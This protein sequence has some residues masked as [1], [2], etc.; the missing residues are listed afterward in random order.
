MSMMHSSPVPDQPYFAGLDA[1]S[2]QVV[3]AVVDRQGALVHEASVRTAEP[4]RLAEALAPYHTP[5]H[6]L[7]VVVETCPFWPWLY[8]LLVPRGITFHLA[9]AQELEAIAAAPRKSDQRDARLLARMLAAGLIPEAYAKPPA[10][11]ER[12]CLVR[13]RAALVRHRTM[14]ANRIHGQLHAAGLLL[15]R[16]CLLRRAARAWLRDTAGPV[17]RP[18]QRRLVQSHWQLVRRLTRMIHQL[19]RVIAAAAAAEPAAVLLAT[20]PGIGAYRG[21]LL[22]TELLPM[23]RYASE[24]KFVG[25]AGLAPI[26]R[27]SA[28]T[29][30]H[31]PLPNA[32]N[33]WVRGALISSVP[34]HLRWAPASRLS[35]YYARQQARL[36]WQVARV[37]TARQ[38]AR[39]IYR[40]LRTGECWRDA[41]APAAAPAPP[42]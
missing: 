36:G 8:D 5:A 3:A 16:E 9:H 33:R 37:A 29:V 32:A 31:G 4:T 22:A 20:I 15:P 25:Y 10:Q 14:L 38:L 1:H 6:P 26:T 11:R 40:M 2:A 7:A 35:Q 34:T 42:A 18:E 19:D 23:S 21:L 13:H 27:R 24:G 30:R 12:A 41:A 17:L 39:V 28:D